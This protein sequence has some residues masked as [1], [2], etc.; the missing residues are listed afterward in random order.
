MAKKKPSPTRTLNPLHFEDLE[1]HRFEDLVR[2][3]LYGF[4]DWRDLEPTGR[5]GGDEGFD[6][7]AWERDETITNVSEEGEEGA[8]TAGRLWQIQ[9]KREKAI[10]PAHIRELIDE[11]VDKE[12][13][14]YGYI[15][16]AATNIS[17]KTY[18]A[19]RER[20]RAK[21]VRESHYWGKDHLEDQLAL[22]EN[23]EILFTFFGISLSPRRRARTAEIKFGINNKNR[24]LKLVFGGA[25]FEHRGAPN[26]IGFLLRD[27]KDTHYPQENKYPDF[28][29]N[30]RWEEHNVVQ[31]N[32]RGVYF[33]VRERYAYFDPDKK[34]WDY[35]DAIDLTIRKHDL[36]RQQSPRH[37]PKGKRVETFWRHMP[38]R[39]QAKLVVY[40]FVAFDSMLIIDEKGDPEYASPHIFVDF[41]KNGPFEFMFANLKHG[42]ENIGEPEF[43]KYSRLKIFPKTFPAA[44]KNRVIHDLSSL[45]LTV[46]NHTLRQGTLYGFDRKLGALKQGHLIRAPKESQSSSDDYYEVT[47]VRDRTV[48]AE[49]SGE[50]SDWRR[51]TMKTFAGRDINDADDVAV[52]EI[53][54]VFL[55]HQGETELTYWAGV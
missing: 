24:I 3:L 5:S 34:E 8:L 29:K 48:G 32:A 16:A 22:P 4:R 43:T 47:D 18:D 7:R 53:C 40:G 41:G 49:L 37:E 13:P 6:I 38:R 9:V 55:P 51:N 15:L 1:P 19:F 45:G 23:D 11:E 44:K 30:R 12:A 20:L 2:R 35:T 39:L 27:I 10:T 17:K 46:D 14:P 33:Q 26:D 25:D 21:G 54:A 50:A 36:N 31:V 28:D 42:G 52:I